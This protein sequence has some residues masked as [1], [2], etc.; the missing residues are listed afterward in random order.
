MEPALSYLSLKNIVKRNPTKV[1]LATG[2]GANLIGQMITLVIQL[3]SLPLF[4]TYWSTDYYGQWLLLSAAPIYFSMIDG[5]L[6]AVAMNKITMLA[7]NEEHI[8][9][10]NIFQSALLFTAIASVF[11]FIVTT[12]I[13]FLFNV[14]MFSLTEN[15]I[16]LIALILAALI[17]LY[18]GLFD[19]IFRA[20]YEYA[21]GIYF[22]DLARLSEWGCAIVG[23]YLGKTILSTS[24]GYLFGRSFAAMLLFLYVSKKFPHYKWSIKTANFDALASLVKPGLT[25]LLFRIGETINI[26]GMTIL[27]G[28]ATGST[29][30]VMFNSYRTISR[31][32]L[33][34]VASSCNTLWPEISRYFGTGSFDS[35]KNVFKKGTIYA[36]IFATILSIIIFSI[37]DQ[38]IYY[39]SKGKIPALHSYFIFFL[40]YTL[41]S[42][43]WYTSKIILVA[44]NQHQKLSIAY[45]SC[46]VLSIFASWSV[47]K[48]SP[49]YG[50]IL[51]LNFFEVLIAWTSIVLVNRMLIKNIA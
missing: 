38:L 51:V 31:A 14:G 7:A 32:L 25:W 21:R 3:L 44:T 13:I 37:F 17:N 1:R 30:L 18:N 50:P 4:L 12:A 28:S 43:F 33:Q 41:V 15:K 10:N 35:I 39:W 2:I 16:A 19:A 45:S 5:G 23:L 40:T 8:E 36:V 29:A 42:A 47:S 46:A 27:V 9:A 34:I 11:I 49:L 22:L 48:Y 26:Q 20:S 24:L 6:I